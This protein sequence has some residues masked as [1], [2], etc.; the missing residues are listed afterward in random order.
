MRTCRQVSHDLAADVLRSAGLRRRIGI[1]M[2]LLMCD[3][4][5]RFAEQLEQM[6]VALRQ[7]SQ[8]GDPRLTDKEAEQ[9]ILARIQSSSARSQSPQTGD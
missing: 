2:H 8:A 3:N 9:R 6:G 1:R 5:R 4:C 7:L